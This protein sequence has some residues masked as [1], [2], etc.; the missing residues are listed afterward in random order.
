MMEVKCG[1]QFPEIR[2]SNDMPL[3]R[4]DHTYLQDD[5]HSRNCVSKCA[6]V[7]T[8]FTLLSRIAFQTNIVTRAIILRSSLTSRQS[9]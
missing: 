2:I 6:N 4:L 8:Q 1:L 5:R 9:P 7:A 3:Q